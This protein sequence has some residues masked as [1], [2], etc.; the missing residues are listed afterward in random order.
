ML[1][2]I[3]S[4]ANRPRA[5]EAPGSITGIDQ[6]S[7]VPWRDVALFTVL[8]Y[9]FA[10]VLWLALR[11]NLFHFLTASRTPSKLTVPSI[12]VLGMFAPAAAACENHVRCPSWFWREGGS[13]RWVGP[14]LPSCPRGCGGSAPSCD[15]CG[16]T[17][18][19]ADGSTSANAGSRGRVGAERR[20]VRDTSVDR[21]KGSCAPAT[22]SR[23]R[24]G[25]ESMGGT[26]PVCRTYASISGPPAASAASRRRA[27]A[28]GASHLAEVVHGA[29]SCFLS[30]GARFSVPLAGTG[31][32]ER[33]P[34]EAARRILLD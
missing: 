3:K 6:R 9:A 4:P 33:G 18:S 27:S 32:S 34:G 29:L 21:R 26:T 11:P 24:T 23:T 5:T 15:D 17:R 10:W 25:M 13:E 28:V 20:S 30:G 31:R 7:K 14:A 22:T 1:N 19:S 8:A 2:S 16:S 12:Y